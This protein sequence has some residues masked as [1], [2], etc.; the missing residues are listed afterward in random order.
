MHFFTLRKLLASVFVVAGLGWLMVAICMP[1]ADL[2][3]RCIVIASPLAIYH[4]IPLHRSFG[5]I[6]LVVLIGS[7]LWLDRDDDSSLY[8]TDVLLTLF[9]LGVVMVVGGG[10][11]VLAIHL[12]VWLSVGSVIIFS[13]L[14]AT[15]FSNS[16]N[17][18]EGI[19]TMALVLA[20]AF[21][22]CAGFYSGLVHG[23]VAGI[24]YPLFVWLYRSGTLLRPS[25]A[26]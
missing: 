24:A 3:E 2:I 9:V 6:W 14:I 12:G 11:S 25:R 5:L 10:I 26:A 13:W 4:D 1:Q 18:R 23:V 8:D 20:A 15:Y 7:I 21:G 22:L 19:L 17:Y 16:L